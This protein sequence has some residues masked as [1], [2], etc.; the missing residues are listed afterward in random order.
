MPDDVLRGTDYCRP[1]HF[2]QFP[3]MPDQKRTAYH[4]AFFHADSGVI[5]VH[6]VSDSTL[7]SARGF[8]HFYL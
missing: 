7:L 3:S 6:I 8:L 4:G 1:V 2:T 5:K